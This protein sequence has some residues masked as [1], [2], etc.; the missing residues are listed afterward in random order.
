MSLVLERSISAEGGA[1]TKALPWARVECVPRTEGQPAR[2]VKGEEEK[3]V[4]RLHLWNLAEGTLH[5]RL[6]RLL[7][8]QWVVME[9]KGCQEAVPTKARPREGAYSHD[10]ETG[11]FEFR[12]WPGALMPCP[13][14]PPFG[15][16][17]SGT[18]AEDHSMLVW[19][20]R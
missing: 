9:A 19:S 11:E 6:R 1:V 13:V 16:G 17:R 20:P 8:G 7:E 15:P 4:R 10:H 12:T 2:S 5:I 14:H 3:L 18:E